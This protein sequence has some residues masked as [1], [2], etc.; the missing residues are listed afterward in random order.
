MPIYEYLCPDCNRIYSFLS[1]KYNP[2]SAPACPKC[3]GTRLT[4]EISR[5]AFV[6]GGS[7]GGSGSDDAG[8]A[9]DSGEFGGMGE[10]GGPDPLEDP[11]VE[12]ELMQLMS[13]AEN[14]DEND[15][16]QL[17]RLMRRMSEISGEPLDG[18]MEEAVRRLESGEDPERIEDDLGDVLGGEMGMGG[19]PYGAPSYDDDLYSM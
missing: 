10:R 12:R 6:R 14:M 4:K 7:T 3:G 18:E 19:G 11:R 5:F 16:R 1:Q 9:G 17:G 13:Q 15:P 8:D 2:E